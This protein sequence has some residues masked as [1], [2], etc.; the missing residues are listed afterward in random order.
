MNR[1][2]FEDMISDYIEND[3]S[4]K[5]RKKFEE[6]LDKNED[7]MIMISEIKTNMMKMGSFPK[8]RTKKIFDDKLKTKLTI[9][10]ETNQNKTMFFGLHPVSFTVFTFLLVF[11][12]LFS[13]KLYN[14]QF[15]KND[16]YYSQ[17]KISSNSKMSNNS[18]DSS[19]VNSKQDSIKNYLTTKPKKDYSNKINL[20]ND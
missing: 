19:L 16:D 7:A 9:K 12:I 4:L 1:N 13:A 11:M 10:K 14:N 3:L 15:P 17:K 2:Q 8:L 6:Y 18:A 5:K 20:V